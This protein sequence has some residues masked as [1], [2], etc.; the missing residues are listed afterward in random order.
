MSVSFILSLSFSLSLSVSHSIHV[1]QSI[2][3]ILLISI[4]FIPFLS[5][6]RPYLNLEGLSPTLS[7]CIKIYFNQNIHI[8]FDLKILIMCQQTE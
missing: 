6:A 2:N 1:S 5:I 8:R 7:D 4:N 3:L